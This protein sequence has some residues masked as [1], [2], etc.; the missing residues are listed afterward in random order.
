M[1]QSFHIKLIHDTPVVQNPT[2]YNYRIRGCVGR[3]FLHVIYNTYEPYEGSARA[4]SGFWSYSSSLPIF[5]QQALE[6]PVNSL[7]AHRRVPIKLLGYNAYFTFNSI[8]ISVICTVQQVIEPLLASAFS[9]C[10]QSK[11]IPS[12]CSFRNPGGCYSKPTE[13]LNSG[14]TEADSESN[15]ESEQILLSTLPIP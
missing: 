7:K 12:S 6:P 2:I 10:R 5:Q 1:S 14:S 3:I 11:P 8:T 9:C 13:L 4:L 15:S